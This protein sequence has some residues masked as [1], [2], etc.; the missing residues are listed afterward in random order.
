MA[1]VGMGAKALNA[2]DVHTKPEPSVQLH[3]LRRPWRGGA[4]RSLEMEGVSVLCSDLHLLSLWSNK[5]I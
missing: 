3:R 2:P 4:R 5:G 1:L